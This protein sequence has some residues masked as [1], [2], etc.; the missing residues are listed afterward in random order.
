[1]PGL[2]KVPNCHHYHLRY[3]LIT[4]IAQ[5]SSSSDSNV[6]QAEVAQKDLLV[7]FLITMALI[8]KQDFH[9]VLSKRIG[10]IGNSCTRDLEIKA[11]TLKGDMFMHLL[12]ERVFEA[13]L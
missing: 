6:Q 8:A 12:R 5:L 2:S 10:E 3:N 9:R 4:C 1:M 11:H 13:C 7:V